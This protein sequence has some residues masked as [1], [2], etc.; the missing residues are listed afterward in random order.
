MKVNGFQIKQAIREET[1][2][3]DLADSRFAGSLKAFPD[4]D[5]PKPTVLAEV[6]DKSERRIAKLQTTQARYNLAVQVTVE[7]QSMTLQEA[8][9]ALGGAERIEKKWREAAKEET[10][11]YGGDT[12]DKDSVVRTRQVSSDQCAEFARTAMRRRNAINYAI[13]KGNAVEVDLPGDLGL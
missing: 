11:R 5:K 6:M 7:G 13:S 3:R 4:E 1:E 9:K 2:E 8:V 10:D 12:R